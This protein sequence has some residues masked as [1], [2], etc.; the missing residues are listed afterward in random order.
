MAKRAVGLSFFASFIIFVAMSISK[1]SKSSR[2]DR[3]Y[4]VM[5]SGLQP[6]SNRFDLF[7]ESEL[8]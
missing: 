5:F 4:F 7:L 1:I 2:L 3:R 8:Q 6:I